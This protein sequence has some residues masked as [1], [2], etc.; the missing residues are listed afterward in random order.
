VFFTDP[1]GIKLE[2]VH[3]PSRKFKRHPQQCRGSPMWL[4]FLEGRRMRR[5]YPALCQVWK[6]LFA[7]KPD[8]PETLVSVQLLTA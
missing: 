6:A 8:S 4:L 5:P 7:S 1:D 3:M 2:V